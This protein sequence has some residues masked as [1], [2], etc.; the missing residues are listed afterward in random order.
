[1]QVFGDYFFAIWDLFIKE[2]KM[3]A[4]ILFLL[5]CVG[6]LFDRHWIYDHNH[7]NHNI[8]DGEYVFERSLRRLFILTLNTIDYLYNNN[9]I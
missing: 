2:N 5:M 3:E 9:K 1:M 8:R 6:S 4:L 7:H